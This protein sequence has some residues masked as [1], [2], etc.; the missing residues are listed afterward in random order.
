MAYDREGHAH[1]V[2]SSCFGHRLARLS[3]PAAHREPPRRA[4]RPPGPGSPSRPVGR[5]RPDGNGSDPPCRPQRTRADAPRTCCR[6]R[7][8]LP[9]EVEGRKR[10]APAGAL[11]PGA[12]PRPSLE[13]HTVT[14][15]ARSPG[16]P[17]SPPPGTWRG[18][19]APRRRPASPRRRYDGPS[20]E[21]GWNDPAE[22]LIKTGSTG[23]PSDR[24]P[25]PRPTCSPARD[26]RR[27][28]CES[29]N[30]D[31]LHRR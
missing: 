10:S 22:P 4:R 12:S 18:R 9:N 7:T 20:A 2:T 17:G 19:V 23:R 21:P 30:G 16:P 26:M 25:P 13:R 24:E 1:L 5:T 6:P 29:R 14:A 8:D 31:S 27:F 3:P 15:P 11:D 28:P